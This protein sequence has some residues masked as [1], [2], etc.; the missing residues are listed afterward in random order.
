MPDLIFLKLGGSIITD[1]DIANTALLDHID[2]AAGEIFQALRENQNLSLLIGHGSGSFGHHAAHQFGT[3]DGVKSAQDW[4]GFCEVALRARQLNQIV[5]ER[6]HMAG[7]HAVSFS[8]FSAIRSSDHQI[9]D[10]NIEGIKSVMAEHIVP[11]IYGDVI[12]DDQMGGTIFS[13]EELFSWLALQ[14]HP[15]RILLGGLE[16]G[17]WK[18]FPICSDLIREIDPHEFL[19]ST[20]SISGSK[21][22]DVTGGMLSKVQSM[23]R[24]V[25]QQPNLEVDIFSA[26][27]PGN[28]YGSLLGD[29]AG[30]RI[31]YPKG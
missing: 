27:Q 16:H 9:A 6:L 13:T 15:A 7:L 20:T 12:M 1:K 26:S 11:V 24:L 22:T 10:W 4:K 5:M 30:T 17:V 31:S 14:L 8:P 18:D 3:R 25:N 19:T 23:C 21:S 28:I 29:H 2:S